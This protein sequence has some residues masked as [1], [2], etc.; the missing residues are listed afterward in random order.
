MDD[1]ELNIS[2]KDLDKNSQ[3]LDTGKYLEDSDKN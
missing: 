1:S 2:D 3:G